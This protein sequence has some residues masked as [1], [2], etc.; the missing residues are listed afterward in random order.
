[1]NLAKIKEWVSDYELNQKRVDA[2]V[3]AL[4]ETTDKDEKQILEHWLSNT[5]RKIIGKE[6]VYEKFK[7]VLAQG[8]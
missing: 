2:L 1:M 7:R 6:E 3:K 5:R 8:N 4:M